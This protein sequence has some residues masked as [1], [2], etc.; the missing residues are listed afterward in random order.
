[1]P[2]IVNYV[3]KK[4]KISTFCVEFVTT[5]FF[6]KEKIFLKGFKSIF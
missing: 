2:S 6:L 4:S 5:T 1:M 3:L